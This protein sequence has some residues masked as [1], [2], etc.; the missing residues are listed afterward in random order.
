MTLSVGAFLRRLFG[1]FLQSNSVHVRSMD[2]LRANLTRTQAHQLE[3]CKYFEVIGGETG[4]LYRIH[5][6][7]A[8]NIDERDG[9]GVWVYTWCFL[10]RGQLAEG[11]VLLAQKVA[12][13]CFELDAR[14][15]A[16]RTPIPQCQ[17]RAVG[18]GRT[19]RA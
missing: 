1:R 4:N 18:F 8:R 15:I 19:L 7:Q 3:A 6:G 10:P 11:D 13:E 2:L 12:L 9:D 17:G 16:V 5:R 14:V